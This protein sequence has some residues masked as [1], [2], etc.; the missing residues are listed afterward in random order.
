MN[1]P[2]DGRLSS[3]RARMKEKNLQAF[4]VYAT[5]QYLNEYIPQEEN[6]RVYLSG[7]TGST[8][9]LL[10]TETEAYLFVDGRYHTQAD[11]EV[12]KSLIHVVKMPYGTSGIQTLR[13][14]IKG[15]VERSDTG[16]TIGFNGR[17]VS[18]QDIHLLIQD[19]L[20]IGFQLDDTEDDLIGYPVSSMKKESNGSLMTIPL[21]ITGK[22][23]S[24]KVQNIR[25]WLTDHQCDFVLISQLDD[26]AYLCNM[27][28]YEI[29]YNSTFKGLA[30]LS[31]TEGHIFL[32]INPIPEWIKE[33]FHG[34]FQV[35]PEEDFTGIIPKILV[36]KTDVPIKVGF[37]KDR[38]PYY[39]VNQLSQWLNKRGDLVQLESP[40][41]KMKRIKT[42]E[43]LKYMTH[44]FHQ[45]DRVIK[46][47]ID[48][49]NNEINSG[50]TVSE[51]DFSDKVK[52]TFFAHEAKAL[53]F[54]VITASG[55]NAAI[56]HYT[57]PD[58]NKILK[59]GDLMLLDTGA[60]FE[61]GYATDL[62][63]TF[64]IGGCE[65]KATVRQQEIYTLVLKSAIRVLKARFPMGTKGV[66]L[67]TLA[68]APLWDYGY[69]YN[70]GTGHGVGICVHEVPPRVSS[71]SDNVLEESMVFS[72][73]PGLYIEGYGGVR[74]EN[75]VTLVRD[76][77]HD[78]WLQV[79]PLTFSPLDS[80]LID[81]NY[82]DHWEKEWLKGYMEKSAGL[83]L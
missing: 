11:L 28:S 8:G 42:P 4:I 73:E 77:Q 43:E 3:L 36:Y 18:Y 24:E 2:I 1:S 47:S 25:E 7:F 80:N 66:H 15:L 59:A 75:L 46:K 58:P 29:P 16:F 55:E 23:S 51:K 54:E 13:D 14:Q 76:S 39:T 30:F 37:D 49:L 22:S 71:T 48:W 79:Q 62:T 5:D 68:R 41:S 34:V 60:Y 26:L 67:D 69:V 61:G 10:V 35:H 70:H 57:N 81:Y 56:I 27:R 12:S 45:A 53:S 38:T 19:S 64:L 74:I 32:D 65:A 83:E 9:D 40:L 6:M 44:S 50:K 33:H 78:N 72:V 82:L 63:R 20:D 17:K 52:A 21:S 31:R